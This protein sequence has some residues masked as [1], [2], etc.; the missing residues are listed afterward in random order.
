MD[1]Q[2]PVHAGHASQEFFIE[3]SIYDDKLK[4][5]EFRRKRIKDKIIDNILAQETSSA[6]FAEIFKEDNT[7]FQ[8]FLEDDRRLLG[9]TSM[10]S[11]V[12]MSM[13]TQIPSQNPTY[14]N[15]PSSS[16][17]FI[18][19]A[20]PS[21]A[22]TDPFAPL[23]DGNIQ[24]SVL[25]YLFQQDLIEPIHGRIEIWNVTQVTRMQFLFAFPPDDF[26]PDLSS[27]DVSK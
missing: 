22:P 15:A 5:P 4:H 2:Y 10:S 21:L 12:T 6:F 13:S 8:Q 3:T 11:E 27:W 9:S 23:N 1:L 25:L 18:P 19:S 24:L 20:Q 16:P 26:D 7:V 14:L 17:S